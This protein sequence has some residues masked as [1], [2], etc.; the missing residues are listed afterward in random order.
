MKKTLSFFALM[1]PLICNSQDIEVKLNCQLILVNSYITGHKERITVEEIFE[2]T[3]YKKSE[4]LAIIPV[5]D[6]G[7]LA[8]VI[9]GKTPNTISVQNYSDDNKWSLTNTV[10]SGQGSVSKTSITIDRNSGKIFYFRDFR[11]GQ[12]VSDGQG[13]C[14]K[15]D[16]TKKLF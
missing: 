11:D 8:S 9:S 13:N 12:L 14:K 5:S 1:L 4:Y 16:T 6:S 10:K 15:V 7:L 2:V 3:Q